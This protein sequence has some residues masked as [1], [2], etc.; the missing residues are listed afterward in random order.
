MGRITQPIQ[1]QAFEIIR[2]RIFEIIAD[3]LYQ[4]AQI[5]YDDELDANVF[6]ERAVPINQSECPAVNI[7]LTEGNYTSESKNTASGEYVYAVDIYTK[8]ASEAGERGDRISSERMGRIM[9]AIRAIIMDHNYITLQF[10]RPFIE[11]VRVEGF[12]IA[13]PSQTRDAANMILGRLMIKVR[14]TQSVQNY[15][16]RTLDGYDTQVQIEESAQGYLYSGNNVIPAEPVCP[17]VSLLVNTVDF[18]DVNSGATF[19]ITV[20]DTLGNDPVISL[21]GSTITVAGAVCEPAGVNFNSTPLTDIQSGNTKNI[22]LQYQDGTT[23]SSTIVFNSETAALIRIPNNTTA[24]NTA[25]HFKSGQTSSYRT[26]DNPTRGRGVDFVTLDHNNPFG[27]TNRYTDQ[28]GGQTYADDIVCDWAFWDQLTGDFDMWYRVPTATSMW[29]DAVD[30]AVASVVGGY[31][32]WELNNMIELMGI[33]QY[34]VAGGGELILLNYAPFNINITAQGERLWCIDRAESLRQQT[35][36][37]N[38]NFQAQT[39]TQN[40]SYIYKRTANESEL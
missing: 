30:G 4:Q 20:V 17:G 6:L 32:D 26:G 2:D 35:L 7:Y 34:E 28:L 16:P 19:E 40:Q 25:N 18:A 3:E 10:A 5:S 14:A 13:N 29:N 12:S 39:A 37:E 33:C 8:A 11:N 31:T 27:N 15:P 23:P 22:I 1:P 38:G 21:S 9:G 24:L 36:V